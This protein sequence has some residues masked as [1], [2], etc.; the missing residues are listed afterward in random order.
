MLQI[1]S[2]LILI[3]SLTGDGLAQSSNNRILL[4]GGTA[5]YGNIQGIQISG[6]GGQVTGKLGRF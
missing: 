6:G 3:I 2:F 4:K 1:V 5:G